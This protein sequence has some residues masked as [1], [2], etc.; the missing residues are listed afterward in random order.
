[1]KKTH[2]MSQAICDNCGTHIDKDC[3]SVTVEV[4][5]VSYEFCSSECDIERRANLALMHMTGWNAA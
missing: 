4:N 5:Q 2:E 3:N 1:M